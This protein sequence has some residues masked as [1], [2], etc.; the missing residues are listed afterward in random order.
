[1]NIQRLWNKML[2]WDHSHKKES[3]DKSATHIQKDILVRISY[4]E[5]FSLPL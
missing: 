3:I 5:N 4:V 1:M 2:L